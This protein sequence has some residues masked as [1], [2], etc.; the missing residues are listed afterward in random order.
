MAQLGHQVTVCTLWAEDR[1]KAD[2]SFLRNEPLRVEAFPQARWR[3]MWNCLLALPSRT[4][5]QAVYSWNPE[6][7]R[8]LGRLLQCNGKDA[9]DV[10]HVEHLRG[11]RYALYLKVP[12]PRY[13]NSVG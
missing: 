5:L 12:F 8:L 10:I 4:P 1:E 6:L 3:S 2:L 9:I 7:A 11:A 13:S